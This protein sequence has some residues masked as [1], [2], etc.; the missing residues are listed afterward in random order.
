MIL[1]LTLEDI[2]GIIIGL[3]ADVVE[4]ADT[5]DLGSYVARHAGSSPVARTMNGLTNVIIVI[6]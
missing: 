4:L 6:S 5:Y 1:V 2:C 3:F